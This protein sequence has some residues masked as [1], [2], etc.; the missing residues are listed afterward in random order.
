M[1]GGWGEEVKH[2]EVAKLFNCY[3]GPGN[4]VAAE[5]RETVP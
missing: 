1:P 2:K 5:E 4:G 3:M